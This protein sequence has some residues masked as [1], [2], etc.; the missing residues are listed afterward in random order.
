MADLTLK[1]EF[2]LRLGPEEMRLVQRGLHLLAESLETSDAILRDPAQHLAGKLAADKH[3]EL[4]QRAAQAR[5]HHENVEA[6]TP[7]GPLN[8]VPGCDFP[9]TTHS[10]G[11][12]R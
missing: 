2:N 3:R 1:L 8:C 10:S 12:S 11:C 4:D 6:A 9:K 5:R 7:R